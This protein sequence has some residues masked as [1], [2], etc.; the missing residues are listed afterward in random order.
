[1]TYTKSITINPDMIVKVA[2]E[3]NFSKL[4]D[5]LL[6]VQYGLKSQGSLGGKNKNPSILRSKENKELNRNGIKQSDF[7]TELS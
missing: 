4:I 6:R 7:N 3:K 5:N 1:M 2:Q